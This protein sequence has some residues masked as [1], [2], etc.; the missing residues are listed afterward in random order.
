M[1]KLVRDAVGYDEKRG[2]TV[3]VSS[4]AFYQA[5]DD[6]A[7]AEEPGFLQSPAVQSYGKQ[8][9]AAV[10]VLIVVLVLVKPLLRALAGGAPVGGQPGGTGRTRWQLCR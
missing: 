2:D 7:E 9:L 5:P 6:A 8:G 4:M 10:L 1:T 3:S